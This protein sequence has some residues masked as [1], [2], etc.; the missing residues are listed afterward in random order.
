MP[1]CVGSMILSVEA[2]W[3]KEILFFLT[4]FTYGFSVWYSQTPGANLITVLITIHTVDTPTLTLQ[5][6]ESHQICNVIATDNRLCHIEVNVRLHPSTVSHSELFGFHNSTTFPSPLGHSVS[7]EISSVSADGLVHNTKRPCTWNR[8]HSRLS[9]IPN[10]SVELT[11]VFP[12]WNAVDNK[13]A[14]IY[15]RMRRNIKMGANMSQGEK[16]EG[17]SGIEEAKGRSG[18]T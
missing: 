7:C 5:F 2:P 1:L 4:F 10:T 6:F 18:K 13:V 11:F 12:V 8:K 3:T 15:A 9:G 14:S 17:R 16:R